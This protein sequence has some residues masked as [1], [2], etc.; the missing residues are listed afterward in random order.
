MIVRVDGISLIS[1]ATLAMSKNRLFSFALVC[2]ALQSASGQTSTLNGA[3]LHAPLAL[4]AE[5]SQE[6]FVAMAV[7]E[8]PRVQA[9]RFAW[10]AAQ[11]QVTEAGILEDPKLSVTALPAPIETAAGRQTVVVGLSQKA[12]IRQKQVRKA[13]IANAAAEQARAQ[14]AAIEREVIS[15][16]RSAFA[17]LLFRQLALSVLH[18]E[19]QLLAEV[20]EI[21]VALYKTDKV[22]QQDI[23]QAE[24][25]QLQIEQD[26]IV[27]RQQLRSA[28]TT[29]ARWLQLAPDAQLLAR[30]PTCLARLPSDVSSLL[31]HAVASRPELHALIAKT[32]Q[33]QMSAS[34]ARLDYVPDPTIGVAWVNI[35]DS[36]ISPVA[37]GDD[38]VLLNV[39]VNLPVYRSRVNAK[40]RSAQAQAISSARAYDDLRDETLRLVYDEF[41]RLDSKRQLIEL[42]R[43]EIVPKANETLDVA[44]KAYSVSKT[45]IQQVL[46]N[47]RKLIRYDLTMRQLEME[48]RKSLASL[49]RAVGTDVV[50]REQCEPTRLPAV[51]P[52][53][54]K[55]PTKELDES[56]QSTSEDKTTFIPSGQLSRTSEFPVARPNVA[57]P[58]L[59]LR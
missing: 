26:L 39:S 13:A 32:N 43:T 53:P 47:W 14:L 21:V 9:A 19:R 50:Q 56:K 30:S 1:P 49:E 45:D 23:A 44:V 52:Q 5:Y 46:D 8:H 22:A 29:M 58:R 20:L 48:Y 57:E 2:C 55:Q 6:D 18:D 42:L 38:A 59:I 15:Q 17:D 36:G 51:E 24:L 34:L 7:A 33:D 54:A 4:P 16:V 3:D 25:A 28:Q 41:T 11:W 40:I 12:P 10:E 31:D 35:A 27:A 37:T